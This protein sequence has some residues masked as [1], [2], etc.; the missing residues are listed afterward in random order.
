MLIHLLR[1]MKEHRAPVRKR[2]AR[3][4]P[5]SWKDDKY[6]GGIVEC[7]KTNSSYCAN[8]NLATETELHIAL[9]LLTELYE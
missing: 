9:G 4:G 8:I 2:R 5:A 3:A 6:E 7:T 1:M